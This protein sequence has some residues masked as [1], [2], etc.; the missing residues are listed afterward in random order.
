[1]LNYAW[2]IA[3]GWRGIFAFMPVLLFSLFGLFFAAF[4]RNKFRHEALTVLF[5][6]AVTFLFYVMKTDN[7]GGCSFGFRFL[8]PIIP[9]L[10]AF[11]PHFFMQKKAGMEL[12]FL[13]LIA[14]LFSAFIALMGI[15]Q[16]TWTCDLEMIPKIEPGEIITRLYNASI[17]P[18]IF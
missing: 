10:F 15:I 6:L 16:N 13:F 5:A 2:D 12:R 8:V 4:Q 11:T 18:K 7:Y 17:I 14:S 9:M 1:M 3:F